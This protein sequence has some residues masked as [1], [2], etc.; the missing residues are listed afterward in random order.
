[1]LRKIEDVVFQLCMPVTVITIFTSMW[2]PSS[3]HNCFSLANNLLNSREN[4][5]MT[6]EL[7][8][9]NRN[10]Y[11]SSHYDDVK[12]VAMAS[13]I[14]SRTIVHSTVYSGADQ[15]K[16]QRSAPLA[17]VW[18]NHWGPVNSL[19]KWPVT[20]KMFPLDDVIMFRV[21][22]RLWK[23]HGLLKAFHNP[24][25]HNSAIILISSDV[26]NICIYPYP[27]PCCLFNDANV[28]YCSPATFKF[29]GIFNAD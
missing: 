12:M 1:M 3:K 24:N 28:F 10:A 19:H 16:H 9:S 29:Q 14:T 18:G 22:F 26:Y 7:Y 5:L 2:L 27:Y 8:W 25:A 6:M 4:C 23:G 21:K 11:G 13:Q 15:R 20:R 17:F